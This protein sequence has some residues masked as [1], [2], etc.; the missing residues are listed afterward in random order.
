MVMLVMAEPFG[1]MMTNFGFQKCHRSKTVFMLRPI[2]WETVAGSDTNS[3]RR[4]AHFK[5]GLFE[6]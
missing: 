1:V 6:G 5:E 3:H 2:R 4:N